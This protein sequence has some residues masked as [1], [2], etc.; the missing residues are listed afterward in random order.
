MKSRIKSDRDYT[1]SHK[2]NIIKEAQTSKGNLLPGTIVRFN[3]K[4]K[5]VHEPRP[6]VL[7]LNPRWDGKLHGLALRMLSEAKLV[8]LTKIIDKKLIEKRK[9]KIKFSLGRLK[10]DIGN[11]ERFYRL[12]M[13]KFL[14]GLNG[15]AY[16]TYNLSGISGERVVDYRFRDFDEETSKNI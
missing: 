8:Q 9:S 4:G 7:V 12:K 14:K 2:K 10:V 1:L 6:L 11:P 5:D 16:R 3:Y 13:K 15:N